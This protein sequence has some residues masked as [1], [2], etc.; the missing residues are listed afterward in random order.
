MPCHK[1]KLEQK[2]YISIFKTVDIFS[3]IVQKLQKSIDCQPTNLDFFLSVLVIYYFNFYKCMY[4]TLSW[5]NSI[6]CSWASLQEVIATSCID[7]LISFSFLRNVVSLIGGMLHS[8]R[9]LL[10]WTGPFVS[11]SY[12]L[13]QLLQ[14]HVHF[15]HIA[16]WV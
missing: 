15:R 7:L 14:M 1:N 4:H 2:W 16:S 3:L 6:S 11:L 13:F 12:I 8:V 5:L 9:K 10:T